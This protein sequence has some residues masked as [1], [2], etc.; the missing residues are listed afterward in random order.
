MG[1]MSREEKDWLGYAFSRSIG[2]QST[3]TVFVFPPRAKATCQELPAIAIAKK[4]KKSRTRPV[5]HKMKKKVWETNRNLDFSSPKM[6]PME[7]QGETR[8][9]ERGKRAKSKLKNLGE[10]ETGQASAEKEESKW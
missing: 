7:L 2:G 8:R 9:T 4:K 1:N 3:S 6:G 5:E 10:Q